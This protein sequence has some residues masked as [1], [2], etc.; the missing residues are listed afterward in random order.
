[1]GIISKIKSV[2]SGLF[3]IDAHERSKLLYLT[4]TYFF[5]IAAYTITRDL[6]NS[7]FI[8]I[9]GRYYI[10]WAR[11]LAIVILVPAILFYS[12]LVDMVR[13]YQLLCF[14][15]IAFSLLS[16]IFA[17]YL[18]HPTIGLPNTNQNPYRIFGWLFY[19]FVEGYSPFLVSVFWAFA[20]SVNSPES[21]KKNYGL[22]VSGSK[23]G[24]ML[25]AGFA[26]MLFSSIAS[27]PHSLT[28]DV[29]VHQ[30][31]LI[32]SSVL[33][34][35]IPIIIF[36]L[37]KYVPGRYLHGYE[38]VYQIEKKKVKKRANWFE[39]L[40]MLIK[41]PYVLGIFSMILFYEIVGTI[42]GYLRLGV[43]QSNATSLAGIS[44]FLFKMVFFTHMI[45]FLISLIGTRTLLKK[46]GMR[47]CL[48][49]IPLVSGGLLLYFMI[50]TTPEALVAAFVILKA[51][52]YAFSWPVRESLYIPAVKEIK[53]KSK[54]WIDAFGAKFAKTGGST[55]NMLIE[56]VRPALIMPIHAFFFAGTVSLWFI[57]AYLLGKRFDK[58][59]KNNEVIGVN[60]E[61]TIQKN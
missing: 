52:N 60:R 23:L 41:Y 6:K 24:G 59:I 13:R 35:I 14:Y 48:L 18:G 40:T 30:L 32:I 47:V 3:D 51:V 61:Q 2:F 42:L 45:G 46:L 10:N 9:I 43:A 4:L 57:A 29:R 20:N 37:M 54:S 31:M 7:V 34:C 15:S 44:S 36:L 12:R 5:V 53:F 50:A 28:T 49:L 16:L 8:S 17:Y 33:L 27:R 22:M 11:M 26:W 55:F 39:G 1:M 38:A 56:S 21:A 25:S 19:F 58:A